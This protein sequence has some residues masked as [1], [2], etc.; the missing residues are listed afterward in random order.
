MAKLSYGARKKLPSGSFAGP[1]RSYPINDAS[2]ARNALARASQFASP[3]VK[4]RIRAKVHKR[5]PGIHMG[6]SKSSHRLLG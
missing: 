6:M 1:H 5:Y 2:H 4:A 3:A